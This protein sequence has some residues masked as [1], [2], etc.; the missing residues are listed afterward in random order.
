[1]TTIV[2]AKLLAEHEQI[3]QEVS[4]R[5][6]EFH[7][8]GEKYRIFHGSTNST[9]TTSK[10]KVMLDLSGLD[11]VIEI[12]VANKTALVEANVSMDRLV[13]ATLPYGLV[14]PVVM[15]FPGITTGGGYSGTSGESSSFRHGF[16]DKTLDWVEIILA[17]GQVIRASDSEH[18]DLF[19]GAAGALGTIGTTTMVQL[20]LK[21]A[22]PYVET[23]IHP[24]TSVSLAL[25][26]CRELTKD[27]TIDYIDGIVYSPSEV[28]IIS[29]RLVEKPV[30][31]S[32]IRT[33]SRA[34]DPWYYQH[35]QGCLR[36]SPTSKTIEYSLIAEYLFRYD[37]GGFW[38]G[39]IAFVYFYV[40]F[41]RFTRWL[42]DDFLHTRMMYTGLLSG[43]VNKEIFVQDL[44]VP[45]DKTVEF[46]EYL[47]TTFN[48]Y[49]LWL[50]P[51]KTT[52]GPS[53][54]PHMKPISQHSTDE[55]MMNVGLWGQATKPP[56]GRSISD[57]YY[58][59]NAD[60]EDKVTQL[61]GTKWLYAKSY[62]TENDFWKFH[63][64]GRKWYD[65]LRIKYSAEGLPTV[66]EKTHTSRSNEWAR[67]ANWREKIVDVWPFDRFYTLW[68]CM[69]SG[70]YIAARASLWKR[71]NASTIGSMKKMQ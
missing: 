25:D 18:A 38:V 63:A 65:A 20:R 40:P 57:H 3:V 47:D 48:I 32:P 26:L 58:M 21:D 27:S 31:N 55:M 37:R 60:L 69:K 51:L 9:R 43:V 5:I 28:A 67:R 22:K 11:R 15:E 50:C 52:P 35:V 62:Y 19:R 41:N 46:T 4:A 71:F 29:G 12:D 66:F 10:G 34:Q 36:S 68:T 64:S 13:E 42:L 39:L 6:K 7:A 45:M 61:G 16:F 2:S 54:H 56:A 49:P 17:D 23:T 44:A 33:F 53:F 30:A 59:L 8:R 24:C 14:P 70:S 1:M